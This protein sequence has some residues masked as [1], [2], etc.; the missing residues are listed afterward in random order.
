MKIKAD[1]IRNLY[2]DNISNN[3]IYIDLGCGTRKQKGYIGVDNKKLEGVNVV[4]DIERGLL[5]KDNTVDKF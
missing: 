3:K 1:D 2:P 5:F 4:C